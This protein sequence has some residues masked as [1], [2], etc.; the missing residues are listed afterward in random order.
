MTVINLIIM[1]RLMIAWSDFDI[2]SPDGQIKSQ[3]R[4]ISTVEFPEVDDADEL[5]TNFQDL[6][7]DLKEKIKNENKDYEEGDIVNVFVTNLV[8]M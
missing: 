1:K 8:K 4:R 5:M 3:G 6:V 7:E 2:F